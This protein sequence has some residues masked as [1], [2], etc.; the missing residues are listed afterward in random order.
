MDACRRA[1]GNDMNVLE[2]YRAGEYVQ[3]FGTSSL[4]LGPRFESP[5]SF[6]MQCRSPWRRC[7]GHAIRSR[8]SSAPCPPPAHDFR[9]VPPPRLPLYGR[10]RPGT[11]K[12]TPP[13]RLAAR[14]LKPVWTAV[15]NKFGLTRFWFEFALPPTSMFGPSTRTTSGGTWGFAPGEEL[16]GRPHGSIRRALDGWARWGQMGTKACELASAGE[17]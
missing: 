15:P 8:F 3:I 4:H 7:D 14:Q 11:P 13:Y 16:G 5:S 9:G 12:R 1:Q 6:A 17:L 2:R 10:V